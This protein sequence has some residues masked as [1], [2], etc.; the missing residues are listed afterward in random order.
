MTPQYRLYVQ[1]SG[2]LPATLPRVPERISEAQA[3]ALVDAAQAWFGGE[4]WD[5]Q[6][7]ERGKAFVATRGDEEVWVWFEDAD[8]VGEWVA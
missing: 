3:R 4:G 1:Q 6:V 7:L 5:V 8:S 2:D